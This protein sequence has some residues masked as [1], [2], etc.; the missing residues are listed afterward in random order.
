MTE[1]TYPEYRDYNDYIDQL[2][3]W[4]VRNPDAAAFSGPIN[5]NDPPP[6]PP[7]P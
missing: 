7:R 1:E 2:R 6:P 4:I 3:Q 5:P